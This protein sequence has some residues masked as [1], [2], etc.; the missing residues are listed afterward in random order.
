MNKEQADEEARKIL[1][2]SSEKV[3]DI[4]KKAKE[5]GNWKMGLDSNNSLFED[6]HRETK[7]KLKVLA[8]LIDEE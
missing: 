5:D 6:L 2:T 4:I 3:D 8:S 7:E 1:Q